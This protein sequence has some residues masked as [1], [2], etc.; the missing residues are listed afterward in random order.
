M[1]FKI[2]RQVKKKVIILCLSNGCKKFANDLADVLWEDFEIESSIYFQEKEQFSDF[3]LKIIIKSDKF[4]PDDVRGK[5]IVFLLLGSDNKKDKDF[6]ENAKKEINAPVIYIEDND[7]K[8]KIGYSIK[9]IL[10][11]SF[12]ELSPVYWELTYEIK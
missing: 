6:F 12:V 9:R 2:A 3:S 10:P 8:N 1:K 11:L 4:F 7:Y 5:Q